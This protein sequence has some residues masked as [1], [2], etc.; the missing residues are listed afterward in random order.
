M[1]T[2]ITFTWAGTSQPSTALSWVGLSWT[3]SSAT[4]TPSRSLLCLSTVGFSPLACH[5][6]SISVCCV[7]HSFLRVR[8]MAIKLTPH[9][10]YF[11]LKIH[12]PSITI[13]PSINA[14]VHIRVF[15]NPNTHF[16]PTVPLLPLYTVLSLSF[17]C[18][19]H[20]P[21]CVNRRLVCVSARQQPRLDRVSSPLFI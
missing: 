7:K 19:Q 14:C 2:S 12:L 3:L 9:F 11:Y 8:I 10:A 18:G 13:H 20:L 6:Q 1:S 17:G 5:C 16:F 4:N 21:P 15:Q